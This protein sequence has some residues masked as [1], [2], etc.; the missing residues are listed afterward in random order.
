MKYTQVLFFS[1]F[2][3]FA[4]IAGPVGRHGHLKV[5]GVH[6]VDRHGSPVVLKGVSFGWHN[7]W[8]R[9]Y[10]ANAV[11]WLAADWQC[12]VVRAAMGVEPARGYIAEPERS[13]KLICDLV[14]AAI[15]NDIYVIIDW[16]S[17]NVRLDE[18]K[19]FFK[20]MATVYG[21]Y[22][23][24]I[25]EIFNEPE[26]QSWAEVKAYSE[27]VVKTIRAVD[28]DNIILVG[29]S[30]WDQDVDIAAASPL[31]GDANLMYTLHFYAAT[32]R[33]E[34]RDKAST[35][36]KKGLPLLVSE[37]AGME[38]SGDGP[39]DRDQWELWV[40]WMQQH[41]ISWVA[42]SISDK[43][44]TC[45]MI[46]PAGSSQGQWSDDQ[47]NEWGITVREYLKAKP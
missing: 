39:I 32:H 46:R 16:H 19:A 34:L 40:E 38:A 17:H 41:N 6:L 37:C 20:K 8:P 27:E 26:R 24:V 42:W 31:D 14:D 30:H 3:V 18:A 15:K 12:T 23:N 43:N 1:L 36:L 5:A 11:E 13:E 7:W 9:F 4:A 45:S 44:E 35:A 25:Y 22:P 2:I 10:N 21:Q 29:S 33:Q 28:P 47:L